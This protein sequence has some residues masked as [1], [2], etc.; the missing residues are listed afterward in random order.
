MLIAYEAN[1]IAEELDKDVRFKAFID[2]ELLEGER[3]E[4]E[5]VG[6]ALVEN[7][8]LESKIRATNQQ[9]SYYYDW[10]MD[11]SDNRLYLFRDLLEQYYTDLTIP[12]LRP[13][14]DP[15]WDPPEPKLIGQAFI[16]LDQLLMQEGKKA[17][18]KIFTSEKASGF[19][20]KLCV[21]YKATD[22]TF[23]KLPP[24]D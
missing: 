22:S 12:R 9:F 7:G 18:R 24:E 10:D 11:T 17:K 15:F 19:N 1:M 3:E 2:R 4:G 16:K 13:E 14:D 23:K 21:E 20:G 6:E 8:K 5:T